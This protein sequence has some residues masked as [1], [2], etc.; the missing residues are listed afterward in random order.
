LLESLLPNQHLTTSGTH[1]PSWRKTIPED[2]KKGV[3]KS[4]YWE[5]SRFCAKLIVE[6]AGFDVVKLA[7]L[8]DNYHQVLLVA[9]QRKLMYEASKE[10]KYL[11]VN[12][13]VYLP[14]YR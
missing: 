6:Q 4:E 11:L 8:V 1:K 7:S 9:S 3:T 12:Y 14:S 2:W 13:W 10:G 5:H